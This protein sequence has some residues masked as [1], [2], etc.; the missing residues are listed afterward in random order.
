MSNKQISKKQKLVLDYAKTI[1]MYDFLG[2]LAGS[3]YYTPE[4]ISESMDELSKKE[5]AQVLK[6][7][8]EWLLEK[9][10]VE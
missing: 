10:V 8:V 3:Y 9:D 6:L 2:E 7:Y 1:D 4:H 5:T